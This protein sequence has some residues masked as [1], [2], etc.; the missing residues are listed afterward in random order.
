MGRYGEDLAA[1]YLRSRGWTILERN[2]RRGR[3]EI[4]LVVSR[5]G[6]LAFVEVKCRSSAVYG[7]PLDAISPSKR[8]EMARV[9]RSWLEDV[10]LPPGTGLRYDAVAVTLH[11]G[12]GPEVLHIPDAWRW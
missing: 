10:S 11:P 6:V 2:L 5:G 8:E 3:G 4:D 1:D 12:S 7:H 9:A